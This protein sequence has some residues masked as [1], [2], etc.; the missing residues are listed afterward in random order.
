ME[1]DTRIVIIH[2]LFFLLYAPILAV[3]IQAAI[4]LEVTSKIGSLSAKDRKE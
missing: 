2:F 3:G 1:K 4:I